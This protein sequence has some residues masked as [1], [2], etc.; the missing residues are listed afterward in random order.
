MGMHHWG[1]F[2]R[3]AFVSDHGAYRTAI[4]AFG[5]LI[6]GRV[7]VFSLAELD[8]AKAWVVA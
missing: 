8:D 6:P 4:K 2:E 7:N 3:I 5:F 1:D